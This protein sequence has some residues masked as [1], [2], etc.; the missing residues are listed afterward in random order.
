VDVHN[1]DRIFR[2]RR[3]ALFGANESP[4]SVGSSVL[5]NLVSGGF[6][7]VIYPVHDRL[8][9]V[10]GISC[11]GDVADLPRTA[12]LAVICSP[13]SEVPGIVE[14]CGDAGILGV[15]VIAAGFNEAGEKGRAL[16]AELLAAVRR[17]PGMRAIGPNCLG[18][19]VPGIGLNASF[20]TSMPKKGRVAFISQSGALCT[21]VLDWALEE[22]IGFSHFVSVGNATDVNFG[23]LID[24]FGE[25]EET[26]A[27]L[28]YMESLRDAHKFMTAA[29]AFART[30]PI[31][32]YKA[33]RFEESA[34][35]AGSHTGALAGEDAVYDAAFQRAGVARVFEIGE[36]FSCAELLGKHRPPRGPRLG[37][38]TNAG[39]PGVMAT[40]ALIAH[41][42]ELAELSEKT[43]ERLDEVLPPFWSH[44][45]PVDVLGDARPK[46]FSKAARIVLED[47]GID[48]VLVILSPQAMTKPTVTAKAIGALSEET[49]KPILAAWLGGRSVREG[50]DLLNKAGVATYTTP[51]EAVRAFMTLVRYARNLDTQ[52]ETPRDIPVKFTLD[53]QELRERFASVVPEGRTTLPETTSKQLLEAYGIP[54]TPAEPA[55]THDEAVEIA[56]RIGYP[57]VAKIWS[58]DISHKTDV[59]G[60]ALN[61]RNE[62]ELRG[63]FL[64]IVETARRAMPDAHVE[65]ITVQP[66]AIVSG[67][68]ELIVGAKRDATFGT[69]VMV[70]TGGTAAEVFQDRALSFPPLSERL[71]R[72][73][74]ES[75]KSWPLLRGYRG[76]PGIDV[77]GVI[78]VL[79]R[80]SYLVADYPEILEFDINP[81]LVTP[82]GALT[83]D[84]RAML[85]P[86]GHEKA[87][88]PYAHLVLRPYPEEF[89]TTRT[90][91]DGS[92]V[93]LRPIRPEDEPRW[94]HLLATCSK[95]TLYARF[96][97]LA[98]FATHET[99][100][101]YCFIDYDREMAIVADLEHEGEHRLA[102]IGRLVGD[103][104]HETA[105]YA[106][107]IGDRWQGQGLGK[108][109]TSYCVDVARGWGIRKI[110]ASTTKENGRMVG[111]FEGLGFDRR[112]D[113]ESGNVF[114]SLDLGEKWGQ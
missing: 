91:A 81:L 42:G 15:V 65:G 38:I 97:Y 48:A 36:I 78:E 39:G 63:A 43:L 35:A 82:D 34:A 90:L 96:G 69:V 37:I 83:L 79:M 84:A 62:D 5:K 107:L 110:V 7:G 16:Q 95:E 14:A 50:V 103:P 6:R 73:M 71:A 74:L 88:R 23:D 26:D 25:S 59:D 33:G 17:H 61:L 3:I 101:R 68:H 60:V 72:H 100:T 41:Q 22:G 108:L 70:G 30:K 47:P 66:M 20:G 9:A 109:L 52:F 58:P 80:F 8:E 104:N 112:L 27:I 92:E 28:L 24:Y 56:R 10:M 29:R 67:G 11:H 111:I 64:R 99:A 57:V 53:R 44:G 40:D 75:L 106:V 12:D 87:D 18:V 55:R 54:V 105:E 85:D 86:S 2:P 102:G 98:Q 113:A 32:A 21:A 93:T 89:V 19:I 76:K 4:L 51:E 49:R 13:A 114:V 77:D 94:K 45:N 31:V 46:R 1:L